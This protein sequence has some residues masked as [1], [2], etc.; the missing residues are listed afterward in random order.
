M[1]TFEHSR[2]LQCSKV[3]AMEV[4]EE[5]AVKSKKKRV[6]SSIYEVLEPLYS[7]LRIFGAIVFTVSS[8]EEKKFK[9]RRTNWI[10][11]GISFSVLLAFFI[12]NINVDLYTFRS[13]RDIVSTMTR[14]ILIVGILVVIETTISNRFLQKFLWKMLKDLHH[15]D[16]MVCL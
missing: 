14:Y 3:A 1:K 5:V 16:K 15:F 9:V 10:H 4:R 12:L 6:I 11:L 13:R 2:A 8:S 7:I